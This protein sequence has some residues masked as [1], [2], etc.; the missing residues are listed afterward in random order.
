VAWKKQL[1]KFMS[2]AYMDF[3][4]CRGTFGKT[5]GLEQ[6]VIYW[7]YTAVVRPIFTY[8][9][10]IGWPRVKLKTSQ[11]EICKLQRMSY[12]GIIGAMRT[13]PTAAMEVL[14]GLPLLHLQMEAEAKIRNYR[15]LCNEQRKPKSESFG[16]AYMSQD[17]E[18][19]TI[20][21]MG[22]HPITNYFGC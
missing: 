12:L 3:W 8:T 18:K 10:T 6:Y 13:A 20:L 14:L 22:S 16:H 19:E 1:D 9:A 11:A 7:T 17:M 2:K 15:L 4:T 5:W 21:Q